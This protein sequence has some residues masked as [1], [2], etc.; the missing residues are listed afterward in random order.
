MKV[1]IADRQALFREGM[2]LLLGNLLT[3]LEV[4]HASGFRG[5]LDALRRN[6]VPDLAL[7]G[8]PLDDLPWNEGLKGVRAA[9]PDMRV[10]VLSSADDDD[11][12]RAAIDNG[13]AGYIP[14]TTD[15]RVM[16]RALELVLNGGSY[17]PPQVLGGRSGGDVL[18]SPDDVRRDPGSAQRLTARQRE[19]AALLAKGIS[20][21]EIARTLNIKEGTVKLHLA[22]IFRTLGVSNRTQAAL[23]A[24]ERGF[25]Q[26]G[27][28]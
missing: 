15:T 19:V 22:S 3:D 23:A 18:G 8:F 4:F 10:V 1:L 24:R 5:V 26:R 28:G 27:G 6:D 13:A 16:F 12:I 17:L 7:L 14:T 20:N 2:A 21:K 25:G 9:A 11:S